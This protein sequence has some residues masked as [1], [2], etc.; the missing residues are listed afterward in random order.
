MRYKLSGFNH[1]FSFGGDEIGIFNTYSGA[2]IGLSPNEYVELKN[3]DGN[4][5]ALVKQGILV[6]YHKNELDELYVNRAKRMLANE[7]PT[8]RI[9][10]TTD[11]NARCFYCYEDRTAKT[12][13]SPEIAE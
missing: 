2:V 8:Y 7:E 6:P 4:I 3:G 12:Y 13:M 1:Y 10:T 5:D 9:F 11:C